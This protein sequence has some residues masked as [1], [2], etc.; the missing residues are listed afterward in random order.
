MTFWF[1]ISILFDNVLSCSSILLTCSA[2]TLLPWRLNSF[3]IFVVLLA[4]VVIRLVLV[5]LWSA[6][7]DRVHMAAKKEQSAIR[8]VLKCIEE[9]KLDKLTTDR[10]YD[11]TRLLAGLFLEENRN[12]VACKETSVKKVRK[13]SKENKKNEKQSRVEKDKESK[14]ESISRHDQNEHLV[15]RL[16]ELGDS[17]IV[18]K[19]RT[20]TFNQ[21][22]APYHEP[23]CLDIYI[24]TG[25][26]RAS[27]IHRATSNVVV[28][29]HSISKD[30]KFDLG[31]TK[32]RIAC[33]AVGGV[34]ARRA[35]ADDIHNVVYT[36][37]RGEKL[38]GKLQIV[39]KS[40]IDGGVDVK[41]KLKQNKSRKTRQVSPR[42][43]D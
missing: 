12:S 18:K 10:D 21:Q 43:R 27:I 6:F 30:M 28:V 9:Y 20:L 19:Q 42:T 35:L 31:S 34:L 8:A 7:V 17:C 24:S 33:A 41:V 3:L 23:F 39:L 4:F 22:T 14:R 16:H 11:G 5:K 1:D 37:R 2:Y 26:V 25:S 40:I 38:E 13:E 36:P 32:N 29:S 15:S